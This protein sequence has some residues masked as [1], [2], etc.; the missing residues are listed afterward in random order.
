MY[1]APSAETHP[2]PLIPPFL[3][4]QNLSSKQI[5]PTD[6]HVPKVAWLVRSPSVIKGLN[7]NL[8]ADLCIQALFP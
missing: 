8:G 5:A 3:L 2:P 1:K 6:K 4:V 7:Q